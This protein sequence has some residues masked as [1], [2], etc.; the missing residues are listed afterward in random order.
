MKI[1]ISTICI[2]MVIASFG[3]VTFTNSSG[4]L[5][6]DF[7][8]YH[9]TAAADMNDDGKDDLV[10]ISKDGYLYV[11]YQQDGGMGFDEN[12]WG[13][14]YPNQDDMRTW[15]MAV[16]DFNGDGWNDIAVGGKYNQMKII[17]S[18]ISGTGYE[19]VIAEGEEIFVQG[20]NCFDINNDGY[21]DIFA[22][23][24]DGISK[25]LINNGDGTFV[26]STDYLYPETDEPSDNSGNYGSL[27]SDLDNNG[28][29]DLYISKCRQGVGNPLDP[30]RIN[31]LF[32]NDGNGGWNSNGADA[33]LDVGW[34][35]WSADAGDF[36]NDGDMD[37]FITNHDHEAQFFEN[38]GEGIFTEITEEANLL[39]AY[40][41][42]PYQS[43]M[44]DFD[45]DGFIDIL[46]TGGSSNTFCTNNGDG[47]FTCQEDVIDFYTNSHA[48]G[49]L[50]NDGFM[51]VFAI[52]GGYGAEGFN[53]QDDQ[54]FLNNG[55]NNEYIKIKLEGN[56]SNYNGIGSRV[57]IFGNWGQQ[58]RDIKSGTSYGIANSLFANFG[59]GEISQVD[60]VIVTWPS[61]IREEFGSFESNQ[62]IV[63]SE[64]TGS[65][66]VDV[67][68][69]SSD[70]DFE[71]FPN[72]ASQNIQITLSQSLFQIGSDIVFRLV[73]QHGKRVLSN[74][75]NSYTSEIDIA[76]ISAGLYVVELI[77]NAGPTLR[78]QIVIN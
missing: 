78:K 34:Q 17:T 33:G 4:L 9:A 49:D 29:C 63:L 68:E 15:G 23:H 6:T 36:D 26:A 70:L 51:D 10:R 65:T 19:M 1:I 58:I 76:H 16:G 53:D 57:E 43:S 18:A 75:L 46:V 20:V 52:Q 44:E 56:Q 40:T 21:T 12:A 25:I 11:L 50:N 72:P 48:I 77:S 74:N 71:I 61:G 8:S 37:L 13:N 35:S 22:C 7:T 2:F 73:D 54:L 39:D 64:G 38:N 45:N 55:N 41:Y 42:T 62:L 31:L 14:I 67:H 66:I 3:Q 69:I 60:N 24:D 32:L 5:P 30:R 59:L 47:T 28:H 27:F